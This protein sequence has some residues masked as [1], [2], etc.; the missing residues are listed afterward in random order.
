MNIYDLLI[1][2]GVTA[3]LPGIL[4]I[5]GLVPV[6]SAITLVRR[7]LSFRRSPLTRDLLRPPGHSLQLAIDDLWLKMWCYLI[8][9]TVIPFVAVNYLLMLPSETRQSSTVFIVTILMVLV[10]FGLTFRNVWCLVK[11]LN[12]KTHGL[13]GEISVAQELNLLM[14]DGCR[15]FHDVPIDRGNIDH[16]VVSKSGIYAVETKTWGKLLAQSSDTN[17]VVDHDKK[18]IRLPDR[19]LPIPIKQLETQINVLGKLLTS[20]VGEPIEVES[21]LAL[22]GWYIK[23]HIGKGICHVINPRNAQK[24]FVQSRTVHSER[25]I[26][27][28]AHQLDQLCRDFK[29]H[30][31]VDKSWKKTSA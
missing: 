24:F 15:V 5:I 29:R 30:D 4:I 19:N 20:A 25:T 26:R 12:N 16:V 11:E 6:I 1:Q 21:I 13:Y 28:I 2:F 10:V 18:V 14:L 31:A 27:Q 7:K 17:V 9:A 22:P 23:S 8:M 3:L